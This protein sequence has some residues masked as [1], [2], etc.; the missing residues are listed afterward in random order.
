[1]SLR[2]LRSL[3]QMLLRVETEL[4]RT[5][6]GHPGVQLLMTIPGIGIQTAEAVMAYIDNPQRFHRV[7]AVG[8]Y[9]GIVPSQDASA[10][11]N[12]L[13][14]SPGCVY[15]LIVCIR[16]PMISL[17]FCWYDDARFGRQPPTSWRTNPEATVTVAGRVHQ[18]AT[19]VHQ[20]GFVSEEHRV[21]TQL[22]RRT[23]LR[24]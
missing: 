21:S 14:R 17:D 23:S 10:Q 4:G 3:T 2:G 16:R 9:F 1:M 7:K 5:G 13:G 8:R 20:P 24:A 22:C 18:G 12:R 6:A 19:P 15:V 11:S